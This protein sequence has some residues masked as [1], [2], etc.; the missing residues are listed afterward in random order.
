[1]KIKS[2]PCFFMDIEMDMM[3][4]QKFE[5]SKSMTLVELKSKLLEMETIYD[6]PKS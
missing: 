3:K 4:V 6:L 2:G 5:N 1:M